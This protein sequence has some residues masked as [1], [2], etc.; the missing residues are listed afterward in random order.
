MSK[1]LLRSLVPSLPPEIRDR[2]EKETF[3]LPLD[4][5]MSGPLRPHLGVL[6]ARAE[7]ALHGMM[8][9][10]A[11]DSVLAEFDAGR[12]HWSRPWALAALATVA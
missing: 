7:S 3:T 2:S 10:G 1:R 9:P 5:W 8:A 4:R 12:L 11:A 6:V